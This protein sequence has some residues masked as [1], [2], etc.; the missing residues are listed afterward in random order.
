MSRE[1]QFVYWIVA[2]V[3]VFTLIIVLREV[4]L[5]FVMGMAIAYF[6]DPVADRLQKWGLSRALAATVL[7][8]VF[9]LVVAALLTALA[10]I[11]VSQVESFVSRL[12]H[13]MDQMRGRAQD[14]LA[15]VQARLSP[16]DVTRLQDALGGFAGGAV[17]WLGGVAKQVWSGGLVAINILS[18][19]VITPIVTFYLLRDW[20]LI[21][22]RLDGWLPRRHRATIREQLAEIDK[23]LAGFARGQAIVC[24]GLG[25]YYGMGL[26]LV[27]LEF[28]LIVGLGTGFISFVPYFGMLTGLVVGMGLAF[29]QFDAWLPIALVAATFAVGQVVEGNFVTPKLVGDQIG[30]HPVWMIFALLAGGAL[31]GF[32]GV[33]LSI[34]VAATIGVL[35]RFGLGRYLASPMYADEDSGGEGT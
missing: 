13:Y 4:L 25:I 19:L 16:E 21:V 1:R 34:P 22:K 11:L 32:M 7:T 9:L 27:G 17:A 15:L 18:L 31:F 23:T 6:L 12:P 10:P 28:G 20:D 33:L 2:L 29:A 3:I 14:I 26:T 24:L 30:L 5:P 35:M 8:I